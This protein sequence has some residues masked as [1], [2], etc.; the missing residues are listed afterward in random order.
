MILKSN[1]SLLAA[2]ALF[3]GVMAIAGAVHATSIGVKFSETG[4]GLTYPSFTGTAGVTTANGGSGNYAQANWNNVAGEEG[5][6]IT[7]GSVATLTDSTGATALGAGGNNITFGYS[8]AHYFNATKSVQNGS[9]AGTTNPA[10]PTLD[11][12]LVS[13]AIENDEG[14]A[15][16]ATFGNVNPGSYTVVL[17]TVFQGSGAYSGG[18]DFSINGGTAVTILEQSGNSTASTGFDAASPTAWMS[19]PGASSTASAV[20]NYLVFTGVTPD[21]NG[22]IAVSWKKDSLG[23]VDSY[24]NGVDAVQLVSVPDPAPLV[25]TALGGLG[26]ML[27][28]RKTRILV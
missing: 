14:T 16:T 15:A 4:D 18:A 7:S 20:S 17:Y 23:G 28:R 2:A 22:N 19:N 1:G 26:L 21:A 3:G 8:T 5:V 24:G 9:V 12:Q 10:T 13:G 6:K 27:L 11:Q 25:L